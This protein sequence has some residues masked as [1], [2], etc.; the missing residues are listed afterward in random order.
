VRNRKDRE[1]CRDNRTL[2]WPDLRRPGMGGVLPNK[3]ATWLR[4]RDGRRSCSWV[5]EEL[6]DTVASAD[7]EF[8]TSRKAPTRRGTAGNVT[9]NTCSRMIEDNRIAPTRGLLILERV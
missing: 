9:R 7:S 2:A 4:W 1:T 6:I 5:Y 8:N 3:P